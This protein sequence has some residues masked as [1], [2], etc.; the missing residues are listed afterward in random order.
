MSRKRSWWIYGLGGAGALAWLALLTIGAVVLSTWF[1][2]L[3]A[4]RGPI[5]GQPV[6]RP[7]DDFGGL[8]AKP[9]TKPH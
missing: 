2:V 7:V 9:G 4:K 6:I 5:P 1:V 8:T 3:Y